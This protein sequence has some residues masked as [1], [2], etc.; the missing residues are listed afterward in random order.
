MESSTAITALE[1]VHEAG[2]FQLGLEEAPP[3]AGEFEL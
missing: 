1:T 3:R 2:T